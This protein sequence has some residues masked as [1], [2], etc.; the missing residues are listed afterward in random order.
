MLEIKIGRYKHYKG[1]TYQ[2]I[3]TAVH[4]ETLEKMVIYKSEYDSP[5]FKKGTVWVRPLSMFQEKININGEIQS[6]FSF[7]EN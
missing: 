5:D 1:N 3:D 6:R 7:I 2:V 4:S